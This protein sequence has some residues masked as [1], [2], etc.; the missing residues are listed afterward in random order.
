V[1]GRVADALAAGAVEG[2]GASLATV[3]AAR[4]YEAAPVVSADLVLWPSPA[5]L[6]AHRP[7]LAGL[8]SGQQRALRAAG[9]GLA[10]R[11][12]DA[13]ARPSALAAVLCQEGVRFEPTP[14]A[15]RARLRRRAERAARALARDP[16]SR[17]AL[18]RIRALAAG[19]PAEAPLAPCPAAGAG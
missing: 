18:A 5:A 10:A 16:A 19:T 8:S 11:S 1:P 12:L 2:A 17:R 7:S 3:Q 9:A 13:Q 6:V 15:A 4:L 14:A